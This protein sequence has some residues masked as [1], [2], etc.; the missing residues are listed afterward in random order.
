MQEDSSTDADAVRAV[1]RFNQYCARYLT[2]PG[3]R[4]Q[5]GFSPT[6][7]RVLCELARRDGHTASEIS[8]LLDINAGY[9]SRILKQFQKRGFLSRVASD[10][11]AR[12]MLLALTPTGR[13]AFEELER[14][15]RQQA[16]V[17]LTPLT[18]T[19]TQVLLQAMLTIEQILEA[20]GRQAEPY[21][22]RPHRIG[23]IAW[24]ASR[25]GLLYAQEYDWNEEFEAFVA[26]IGAHFIRD[27][28]PE[29]ER[30]WIAERAGV[31]VGS[32]FLVREHDDIAK[33][34]MLYVEPTARRLGIGRRLVKEAIGFAR[35]REYR[36]VI[37]WTN[38]I[39]VSARRIYQAAGFQLVQEEPHHSFGRDL[40]GQYWELT[41]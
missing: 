16:A 22:L 34:R 41:L 18:A 31:I 21:V 13:A 6:E 35:Q 19:Q 30:C 40:I 12:R 1:L 39:L 38:D 10:H 26:E 5:P 9:L 3:G 27:Y 37:L 2:L 4:L 15:S 33:L 14:T 7:A 20:P 24:V 36:K 25:Q 11:D 8:S 32:I 29:W 23:D 28:D 17:L